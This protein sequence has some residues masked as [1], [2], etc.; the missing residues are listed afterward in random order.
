MSQNQSGLFVDLGGDILQLTQCLY[1]MFASR[2]R[3][4]SCYSSDLMA[5]QFLD[6]TAT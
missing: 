4:S 1:G 6:Q 5:F 2:H 3:R